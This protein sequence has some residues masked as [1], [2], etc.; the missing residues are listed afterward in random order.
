MQRALWSQIL[1]AMSEMWKE[2][3]VT[4]EYSPVILIP[5]ETEPRLHGGLKGQSKGT[6][7]GLWMRF[8]A[9]IKVRNGKAHG[10]ASG[11]MSKANRRTRQFNIPFST[12][13][14][15]LQIGNFRTN[16]VGRK[17]KPKLSKE[18]IR[19][20]PITQ[21]SSSP[22]AKVNNILLRRGR[23]GQGVLRIWGGWGGGGC[24]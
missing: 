5:G 4:K 19:K 17:L 12:E 15:D 16:M 23:C 22:K 3:Q 2:A 10:W 21:M 24:G 13:E 18:M 6:E 20:Y 9:G 1:K 8:G 11:V 14:S 7:R